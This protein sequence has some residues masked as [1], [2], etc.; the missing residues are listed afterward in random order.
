MFVVVKHWLWRKIVDWLNKESSP[1]SITE[2]YD[3][4]QLS[5]DTQ[6][7]DVVLVEGR[8]RV[9]EVIKLITL[10]PW[11][12]AAIVIGSLETI[13]NRK[14]RKKIHQYYQGDPS[15][16]LI[17]ESLLGFGTIITPLKSYKGQHLRICRALNLSNK[18]QLKISSF[19]CE[20]LGLE[21]DVRQLLDLARLMFPYAIL[22]RK[23]RSSLF[24]H[25]AGKPTQIVCSSMIAR[26][27][28]H[29]QY[30]ILPIIRTD[31]EDHT[32]FYQRNFRLYVPADFDYSPFFNVVKYPSRHYVKEILFNR[33]PWCDI[34][35]MTNQPTKDTTLSSTHHL[36]QRFYHSVITV[37]R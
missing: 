34:S 21:Y 32:Q 2:A 10:S 5:K 25:N 35:K 6:I 26:C 24:Q 16:P 12:H 18:D 11:T 29:V 33:L 4:E 28:Q 17:I 14:Q 9:S 27:F 22:P 23:W 37:R 31:K 7:A 36:F 3:F 20:H 8:S 13:N 30:P 19:A 1:S 15:E